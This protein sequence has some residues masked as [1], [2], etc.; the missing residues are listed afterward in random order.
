MK[1]GNWKTK[2]E[3]KNEKSLEIVGEGKSKNS[4]KTGNRFIVTLLIYRAISCIAYPRC[5]KHRWNRQEHEH[6]QEKEQEGQK[7]W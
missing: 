7:I 4:V 5:V 1:T 3:K 2:I 6:E